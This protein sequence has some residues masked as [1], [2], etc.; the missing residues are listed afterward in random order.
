MKDFLEET[1]YLKYPVHNIGSLHI[2]CK[3]YNVCISQGEEKEIIIRYHN[4]RFRKMNI[5]KKDS[6]IYMKEQMAVTFYEFFRMMELMK[7]N[8]LE[9]EIPPDSCKLDICVETGVSRINVNEIHSQNILLKSSSG[10]IRIQGAWIGKSLNAHS[11]SGKVYCLLPGT[12]SDY[13]IDCRAERKDKTPPFYP[14]DPNS[15]RKVILRSNMY[16]P[17]LDFTGTGNKAEPTQD[18]SR[19]KGN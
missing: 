6:G 12:V 17:E 18:T 13:D 2:T 16:V 4:N 7:D 5:A 19:R 14:S 9:I 3:N 11:V 1:K 8:L 15:E 10:Q